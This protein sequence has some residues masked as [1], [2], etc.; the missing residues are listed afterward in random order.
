MKQFCLSVLSVAWL[1]VSAEASHAG[2]TLL[3]DEAHGQR[4]HVEHHGELDL[5]KLAAVFT[6]HGLDSRVSR[7]PLSDVSLAGIDALVTSGAFEALSSQETA[8]VLRFLERGGRLC[9]MLHIA[10]PLDGLCTVL[11]VSF[12]NGVIRERDGVLH[13]DPL[14]FHVTRMSK[15]HPLTHGVASFDVFG[16][17]ALLNRGPGVNVLAETSA[18]AWVDLKRN[19]TFD[20]QDAG[21]TFPVAVGGDRGKGA[22]VVFGDDALFQNRY[23]TGGNETLAA[24]LARWLIAAGLRQPA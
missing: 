20:P 5:S 3:I 2:S 10:P 8:A 14:N 19:Q 1:A 22:F 16:A 21:R 24:N 4:F 6:E 18:D 17:W 7:E 11:E 9:V 23:L 13:M 12:S 15:D